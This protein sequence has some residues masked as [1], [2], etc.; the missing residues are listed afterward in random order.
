MGYSIIKCYK[1]KNLKHIC[2]FVK[3]A[4]VCKSCNLC[5]DKIKIMKRSI[6]ANYHP[7]SV[8]FSLYKY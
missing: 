6:Q 5:R 1:C 4:K 3:Y 8:V 7:N 2:Y